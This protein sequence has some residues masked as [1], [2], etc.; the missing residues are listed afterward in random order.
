MVLCRDTQLCY[1]GNIPTLADINRDYSPLAAVAFLVPQLTNVAE[2]ANCKTS[3]GENQIRSCAEM[4]A[5]EY[6]Y[7]KISELMLFFYRFKNGEYEQFY[8]AVSP[9]TIMGSLKRFAQERNEAFSAYES[10]QREIQREKD[11]KGTIT[12]EE[13]YA[14]LKKKVLDYFNAMIQVLNLFL[15]L[16]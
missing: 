1:F 12:A 8:G 3:F 13:Y 15:S 11:R 10:K 2:F 4:I 5:A 14:P 9:M 16:T 6:Y 7:M